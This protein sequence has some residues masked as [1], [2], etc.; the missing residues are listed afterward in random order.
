MGGKAAEVG[1]IESLERVVAFSGMIAT[2]CVVLADILS[3]SGKSAVGGI[4]KRSC[5]V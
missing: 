4:V 1:V 5:D 2:L 3:D